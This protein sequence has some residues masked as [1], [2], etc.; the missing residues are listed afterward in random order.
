MT[1]SSSRWLLSFLL[2]TFSTPAFA[3]DPSPTG[4]DSKTAAK[5]MD[6]RAEWWMTWPRSARDHDTFCVSCHTA[7]PYVLGRPALRQSLGEKAV[8]V[9]EQRILDNVTKR[10][11]IWAELEPFYGGKP[12]DPKTSESWGTESVLNALVLVRYD[13]ISGEMSADTKTALNTMWKTQLKTGDHKGSWNWLNFH[14]APWESDDSAFFGATLGALATGLA[15]H[16]YQT[17][18]AIQTD[19]TSLKEYLRA[20]EPKQSPFNRVVLLWAST[21]LVGL[22]TPEQQTAII[23]DAVAKQKEDGGWTLSTLTVPGFKRK[24]DTPQETKTDGY[25]TGL[26]TLAL[27]D[28]KS[29]AGKAPATR[30]LKW[31]SEH[32]QTEDGLWPAYSLNKNRDPKSDIGKFMSDAA[33]AYAVLAL[34]R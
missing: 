29:A 12:D 2:L 11:R 18:P 15:P 24:D 14:Y 6:S 7:V 30:G 26:I 17:T 16:D 32:Q 10:V 33:T 23:Q 13:S 9:N 19:L 31:L 8:S 34:T 27:L 25:A 1:S 3:A 5:Y 21:K 22:L 4:W 28:S 20:E